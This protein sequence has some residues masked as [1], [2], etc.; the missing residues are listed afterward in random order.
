MDVGNLIQAAVE[1]CGMAVYPEL[2]DIALIYNYIVDKCLPCKVKKQFPHVCEVDGANLVLDNYTYFCRNN[3]P[4]NWSISKSG[5]QNDNVITWHIE[6]DRTPNLGGGLVLKVSGVLKLYNKGYYDA[7]LGNIVFNLQG[8]SNNQWVNLS[9]DAADV[10][11]GDLFISPNIKTAHTC[12]GDYTL[13]NISSSVN[14][15]DF[16]IQNGLTVRWGR[17]AVI[18]YQANFNLPS[19]YFAGTP[20]QLQAIVTY[21]GAVC[22]ACDQINYNG[23]GNLYNGVKSSLVETY[24]ALPQTEDCNTQVTLSD[25]PQNITGNFI[26]YTTN[27]GDLNTG[28]EVLDG[29]GS[30]NFERYVQVTVVD[31]NDFE[32]CA[33]LSNLDEIVTVNYV[34]CDGNDASADFVC[35]DGINLEACSIVLSPVGAPIV[36]FC[37][38]LPDEWADSTVLSD[39]FNTVYPSGLI[40]GGDFTVKFD[41]FSA[42]STFLNTEDGTPGVLDSNHVDPISTEAGIFAS[43]VLAFK[44]NIEMSGLVGPPGSYFGLTTLC[45]FNLLEYV[46]QDVYNYFLDMNMMTILQVMNGVLGGQSIG[47]PVDEL[48]NL[49]EMLNGSY[50]TCSASAFALNICV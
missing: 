43:N 38:F 20:L 27:I 32:N 40:V 39:M 11:N 50:N 41:S 49:V 12:L 31:G 13:N 7:V 1:N 3:D 19:T 28:I 22:G 14:F 37:T 25:P 26:N 21:S 45:D 47:I 2:R 5:L 16:Q 29:S 34:D 44:L 46:S 18:K 6:V 30:G 35:C 15:I 36:N 10:T 33:F 9:T 48:N 8:R 24:F 4:F 23:D 17:C 42:L